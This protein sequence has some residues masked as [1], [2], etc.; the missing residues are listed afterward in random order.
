[1]LLLHTLLGLIST[2]P[3]IPFFFLLCLFEHP[4]RTIFHI[5]F[6]R[7]AC[8]TLLPYQ[9][10]ELH[11]READSSRYGKVWHPEH[12]RTYWAPSQQLQVVLSLWEEEDLCNQQYHDQSYS[13][14]LMA[15]LISSLASLISAGRIEES[16]EREPPPLILL[17]YSSCLLEIWVDIRE[18]VGGTFSAL[19]LHNQGLVMT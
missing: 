3:R 7:H 1:M 11:W 9:V 18:A 16:S 6:R 12:W 10:S 17:L 15:H 13:P 19:T 5:L 8:V 4:T 14:P 2:S